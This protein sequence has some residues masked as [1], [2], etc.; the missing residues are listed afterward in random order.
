MPDLK[1]CVSVPFRSYGD[2]SYFKDAV[3]GANDAVK[4]EYA[5]ALVAD[6]EASAQEMEDF[7]VTSVEFGPAPL[8]ALDTRSLQAVMRAIRKRYS[9][10][11]DACL[12]GYALPG[13]VSADLMGFVRGA[14]FHHLELQLLSADPRALK[15]I[16]M[17]PSADYLQ[18]TRY[19]MEM[20]GGGVAAGVE[21]DAGLGGGWLDVL[22]SLQAACD[23][24]GSYVRVTGVTAGEL[25]EQ[26]AR[27]LEK[28]GY[29]Y[30]AEACGPG[31]V[32]CRAGFA[33]PTAE[34]VAQLGFGLGALTRL[35]GAVCQT[36]RDLRCYCAHSDDFA[37][38][39]RVVHEG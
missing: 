36:T 25:F 21:V 26:C 18:V 27:Y 37:Q 17:P 35:E 39:A 16:G 15:R 30:Q 10:T 2:A 29:A 32:F 8:D 13:G 24:E 4:A 11:P 31:A 20:S 12:Y 5:R 23:F 19:V 38:I 28:R 14:G 3:F 6:I 34:P 9:V 22:H 33:L 1:L 7:R